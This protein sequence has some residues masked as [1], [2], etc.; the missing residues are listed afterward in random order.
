M[1][2]VWID[3]DNLNIRPLLLLEKHN[4]SH[5]VRE[6]KGVGR[7]PFAATDRGASLV[8]AVQP[9]RSLRRLK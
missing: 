5:L 8:C 1:S 9:M 3:V 6:F 7:L 4:V 2:L